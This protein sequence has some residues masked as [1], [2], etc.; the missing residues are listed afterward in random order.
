MYVLVG[1]GVK[2]Q[3]TESLESPERRD[4]RGGGCSQRA[5]RTRLLRALKAG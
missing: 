1:V 4:L 5:D 2:F 3:S